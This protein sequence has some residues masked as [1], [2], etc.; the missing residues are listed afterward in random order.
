MG[1]IKS[2]LSPD[3]VKYSKVKI[4]ANE[5]VPENTSK[6]VIEIHGIDQ[7]GFGITRC[8][9]LPSLHD[10]EINLTYTNRK[11]VKYFNLENCTYDLYINK[12]VIKH[13][14]NEQWESIMTNITS[15]SATNIYIGIVN[16]VTDMNGDHNNDIETAGD[17]RMIIVHYG[18]DEF[19]FKVGQDLSTLDEEAYDELLDETKK[20]FKIKG[21]MRKLYEDVGGKKIFVDDWDDLS[22]HLEEYED[23]EPLH[24]HLEHKNKGK[25][26]GK[27]SLNKSLRNWCVVNRFTEYFNDLSETFKIKSLQD[28]IY[29][30]VNEIDELCDEL[31]LT[32]EEKVR[33]NE[34]LQQ[35]F[36]SI[37]IDEQKYE[38]PMFPTGFSVV[39][40]TKKQYAAPTT[41]SNIKYSAKAIQ[42]KMS[43][44]M[45]KVA[46]KKSIIM[47]GQTGV[48][49]TTLINAMTNYIFDVEYED[50]HR[51]QLIETELSGRDQSHSQTDNITC[52]HIA[53][54]ENGNIDYDL[55]IIDTPGFGDTRGLLKDEQIVDDLKHL[56]ATMQEDI[57]A[58]CLVIKSSESRLTAAQ[59]YIFNTVFNLWSIDMQENIF[60]LLTFCDCDDPPILDTLE[61]HPILKSGKMFKIN[62]LAFKQLRRVQSD[63]AKTNGLDKL[64]WEVSQESFE[65]FFATLEETKPKSLIKSQAILKR[66]TSINKSVNVILGYHDRL[67]QIKQRIAQQTKK[68][69]QCKKE[70]IVNRA[71]MIT[72]HKWVKKYQDDENMVSTTCTKC[73]HQTCHVDCPEARDKRYCIVMDNDGRCTMCPAN[74]HYSDHIDCNY[75]WTQIEAT[76][77]QRNWDTDP[78]LKG[79]YQQ[80]IKNA[81]LLRNE[82]NELMIIE[83]GLEYDVKDE[84]KL[85]IFDRDYLKT[86]AL[87]PSLSELG[88]Y[89][90]HLLEN[91]Y[92][93]ANR[94]ADTIKCLQKYKIK[95]NLLNCVELY[96]GIKVFDVVTEVHTTTMRI[97][98]HAADSFFKFIFW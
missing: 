86:N 24:L 68:L 89:V 50:D 35:Y 82:L 44:Y 17:Y 18:N 40:H 11:I 34:S 83:K 63:E 91:E 22:E 33:Y 88:D 14:D 95:E 13:D 57:D 46:G 79:K 48:G 59:N 90:D 12:V 29:L 64:F 9:K 30:D 93:S 77:K 56:F 28:F 43:K 49:K 66:R 7:D 67:L 54:P 98:G 2:K 8:I 41:S 36:Q 81:L 94:D 10:W 5:F 70:I 55:S 45:Y 15:V 47:V 21:R 16:Q 96:E 62:N 72:V 76:E 39:P 26:K 1:A 51:L 20:Y 97:L 19:R 6:Y 52:Y 73:P 53:S 58:I 74:C 3:S 85:I 75:V 4:T 78:S 65:S 61:Q 87:R 71:Q 84:V 80:S 42:N 32:T 69:T 37:E 27:V 31:G 23:G 25:G 38:S 92:Q 60:I